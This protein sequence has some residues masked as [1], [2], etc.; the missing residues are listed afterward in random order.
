MKDSIQ[1]ITV[2]KFRYPIQVKSWKVKVGSIVKKD[3]NLG[4]YEYVEVN[5]EIPVT[6]RA[7]IRVPYEG[8]VE[9]LVK[10]DYIAENHTDFLGTIKER[11]SHSVQLHGLCALCGS[12]LSMYL[13]YLF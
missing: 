4:I 13:Q 10:L 5:G 9:S 6:I 7:E 11:C 8:T 3:E 12:D 2:S 1:H